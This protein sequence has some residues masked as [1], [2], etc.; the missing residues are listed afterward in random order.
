MAVDRIVDFRVVK[1]ATGLTILGIMGEAGKLAA[2]ESEKVIRQVV[3]PT[4]LPMVVGVSVCRCVGA[5]AK[6]AMDLGA[7]GVIVAPPWTLKGDAQIVDFSA[8][9]RILWAISHLYCRAFLWLQGLRSRSA[10]CLKLF[11]I[12]T[13]A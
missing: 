8:T 1:G 3:K 6:V 5:L 4:E 7:A 10:R 13:P 2:E 11:R 12:A 9:S